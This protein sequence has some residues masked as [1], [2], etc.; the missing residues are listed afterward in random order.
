M[1]RHIVRFASAIAALMFAM[2][3]LA[4]TGLHLSWDHC[5][6]DGRVS[7]K[8][9]A[10]DTNA[11]SELLVLSFDPPEAK[12]GV[13]GFEITVHIRSSS[14]SLPEWWRFTA[15]TCRVTGMSYDLSPVVA[16][17]CAYS[18]S[19]NAAGG[20]AAFQP[21][22]F[23]PGSLRILAI[24]AVPQADQFSVTPGQEYFAFALVLR[25]I[26]TVGAGACGG[27]ATPVCIGFGKLRI[28]GQV[29]DTDINMYA[30]NVGL[31]GT[32]ATVTWQ[33]AFVH[34]YLSVFERTS[35]YVDMA[36]DPDNSVPARTS[37]WGAVK[38][39]YR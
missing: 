32:D 18:L 2:P 37:T 33:G 19:A 6:A 7:N 8:A 11:G 31:G 34:G 27:C 38:S 10:C 20:I 15:G 28:T 35:D 29:I 26:R 3:A 36:C 14:S 1:S 13:N 24:S 4:A 25:K 5:A 9:F 21:D 22:W 30:G 39:L 16:G 23:G 17:T 12:D